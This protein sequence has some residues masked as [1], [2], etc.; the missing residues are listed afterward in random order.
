MGDGFFLR[1]SRAPP[2]LPAAL[3][4]PPGPLCVPLMPGRPS[5]PH[6][7][8]RGRGSLTGM[9]PAPTEV[10]APEGAAVVGVQGHG[11]G[12]VELVQRHGA[13]EDVLWGQSRGR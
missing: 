2:S 12:E 13:V 10:Q 7:S 6:R 1:E 4:V 3:T 11:A 8:G 5:R 9:G